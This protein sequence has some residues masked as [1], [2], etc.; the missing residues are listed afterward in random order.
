[1][2]SGL[3]AARALVICGFEVEMPA[4]TSSLPS[5][6]GRTAMLPPEPIKTL[7][8]PRSFCVVIFAVAASIRAWTTMM[9][10]ACSWL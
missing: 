4:S 3:M 2:G 7:T 1:M 10:S 8:L 6:P 5:G 9:G